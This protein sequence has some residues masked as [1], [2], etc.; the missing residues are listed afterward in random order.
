MS[1][2][3][4]VSQSLRSTRARAL[5]PRLLVYLAILILCVAGISSI[6]RGPAEEPT[7]VAGPGQVTDT[8][9]EAFA[10]GFAG[11][12]LSWDPEHPRRREHELAAYLPLF[13][14]ADGGLRPAGERREV[15]W[16]AAMSSRRSGSAL[17]VIVA[18]RVS[19]GETVHL[20]VPIARDSRGFLYVAGYPALVGA[21]PL[22]STVSPALAEEV[23]DEAL[24]AVVER[25]LTNYLEGARDNLLADLTSDAV[26]AIPDWRL[27]VSDFDPATWDDPGRRVAAVVT[28]FD[29]EESTWTLRYELDVVK[30]GRWYVRGIEVDPT[31]K[32]DA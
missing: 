14:G 10:E 30:S 21:P 3:R 2:V 31:L 19:D 17:N 32:G 22:A 5:A 20:V 26:V 24:V 18:A 9:A 28:A 29:Q 12:Y 27:T 6:L 4:G 25:A 7:V 23:T 13:L 15:T 11:A 16:V 1:T 8:A